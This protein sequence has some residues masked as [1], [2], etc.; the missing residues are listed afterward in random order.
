MSVLLIGSCE[1]DAYEDT[2]DPPCTRTSYCTQR[3]TLADEEI[4][5]QK[6][7]L[8]VWLDIMSYSKKDSNREIVVS[9]NQ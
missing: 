4:V 7:Q 8:D 6:R 2:I 9:M 3:G 1:N 5:W